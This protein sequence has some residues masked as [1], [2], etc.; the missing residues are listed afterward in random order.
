[1][2]FCDY[3]I[4]INILDCSQNIAGFETFLFGSIYNPVFCLVLKQLLLV[5]HQE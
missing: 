4:H 5:S 1:M 2:M 3:R